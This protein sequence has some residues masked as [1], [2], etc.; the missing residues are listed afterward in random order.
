MNKEKEST[1]DKLLET[2]MEMITTKN[3]LQG[4][5]KMLQQE[6]DTFK[7]GEMSLG[8]IKEEDFMDDDEYK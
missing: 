6:L 3:D 1:Q 2:K 7:G 5:I 8:L 4:R